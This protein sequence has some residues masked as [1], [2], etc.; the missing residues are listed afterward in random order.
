[1]NECIQDYLTTIIITAV[2]LS[3]SL[4]TNCVLCCRL[5]KSKKIEGETP[6]GIELVKLESNNKLEDYVMRIGD[7]RNIVKSNTS[8]CVVSDYRN[9]ET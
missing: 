2:A 9:N 1:M 4:I 6:V 5:Y 7:E 8:P 3:G